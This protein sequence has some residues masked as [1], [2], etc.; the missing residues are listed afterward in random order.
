MKGV[1]YKLIHQEIKAFAEEF[2]LHFDVAVNAYMKAYPT[3]FDGMSLQDIAHVM[4]MT[5]ERIRQI[6]DIA[7]RKLKHPKLGN[8]VKMTRVIVE[9]DG[10][11]SWQ[12]EY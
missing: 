3:K 12:P 4:G 2:N 8:R 1:D 6:E 10:E 11:A 5:R 7:V 9:I